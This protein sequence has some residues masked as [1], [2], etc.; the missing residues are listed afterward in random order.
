MTDNDFNPHCSYSEEHAPRRVTPKEREL[1]RIKDR[2]A[3]F[4]AAFPTSGF[5]EDEIIDRVNEAFD[6][7][8]ALN[9]PSSD[10]K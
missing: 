5:E 2:F 1:Q 9:Q 8:I 3:R 7:I 6:E 4:V 10:E